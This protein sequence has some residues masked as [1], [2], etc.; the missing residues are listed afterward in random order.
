MA[1]TLLATT[2][3]Q[4]IRVV[5]AL[6]NQTPGYTF[7]SNFRTFTTENGISGF[8][9]AMAANFASSTDAELAAIVTG[10]LGLG[11][12][13]AA[14]NAYLEAQF[15]ADASNRGKAVLDAMNALSTLESDATYGSAAAT[16]NADVVASITYS[17]VSTNTGLLAEGAGQSYSLTTGTDSLTGTSGDDTFTAGLSNT[18]MSLSASDSVNGGAGADALNA[19]INAAGTY[20]L[21]SLSGVETITTAFITTAGTMGLAG[22]TD[23]TKVGV[24]AS[25]VNATYT[26]IA[27]GVSEFVIGSSGAINV[28]FGMA[29]G[30]NAGAED[31][32]TLTLNGV[33]HTTTNGTNTIT[34]ADGFETVNVASSSAN[35]IDTFNTG[36]AAT[37]NVSG[38]GNLTIGAA[39]DAQVTTLDGSAATGVLSIAATGTS[40]SITGGSGNDIIDATAAAGTHTLVGGAGDDAFV[41]NATG[42]LTAADTV[43]GGEGTDTI[44]NVSAQ[45]SGITTALTKVTGVEDI[46]VT[47][48]HGNAINLTRFGSDVNKLILAEDADNSAIT[49]NAGSSTIVLGN[50]AA[51]DGGT[52]A[53]SAALTF[54]A[55][56]AGT[57]DAVT[58]QLGTALADAATN[59]IAATGVETLTINNTKVAQTSTT[60]FGA[61]TV[62]S[63]SG[64]TTTVN[65]TGDKAV[66]TGAITAQTIDASGM[67]GTGSLF[68]DVAAVG[69]TSITGS[70]GDDTLV[71]DASSTINGGAGND[72]ITG[73]AN[74]DTLNGG[75]GNDAI[76]T[77][78]GVDTVDGGAGNDT[79][80]FSNGSIAQTDT[81]DG[82]EGTDTLSITSADAL[83]VSSL[84]TANKATMDANLSNLEVLQ[85]S[86]IWDDNFD[87]SDL[88]N[89]S[90]IK[91]GTAAVGSIENDQ[92]ITK[93][94]DGTTVEYSNEASAAAD[95]ATLTMASATGS[96]DSLTIKLNDQTA[97]GGAAASEFGEIAAAGVETI[98]INSTKLSTG[99]GT[100]NT[101]DLTNAAAAGLKTLNI[102]G[103]LAL[104]S[105]ISSTTLTAV[106][107]SSST[108]TGTTGMDL[109]ATATTVATTFTGT[110]ADDTFHAGSAADTLNGG[111]G[112][113]ILNGNSGNDTLN[114][115]V[116]ADTLDGG[117]GNDT[118]NGGDG[119][120]TINTSGGTDTVDGGAGTDTLVINNSA[121]ANIS[122][123]TISNVETLNMAGRATTMT[124]AQYNLFTTVSNAGTAT[125]T[126]AGTVALNASIVGVTLANGTNNVTT[127][128][129]AA[130]Y[131]ITGGTGADTFN[132]GSAAL[133]ASDSF[134]GG[135]G[136]DTVNVT[137]NTAVVN[138]DI[139][140]ASFNNVE[141]INFA[142]TSTNITWTVAG[143]DDEIDNAITIDASSL[144]TGILTLNAALETTGANAITAIGGAADDVI[145]GGSGADVLIGN[146]GD[147][148][149]VGGPGADSF[150]GGAGADTFR[151]V[152]SASST[153]TT[154]ITN[155]ITDFSVAQVDIFDL[156][157]NTAHNAT[158]AR[159][160]Y[161]EGALDNIATTIGMQTFTTNIT[162]V[163]ASTGPT[164]AEM[165]TYF[166]ANDVF[167][168]AHA[169]S[170]VY[171]AAD[172]GVNT[173]IM[174]LQS[175]GNDK[176]FTALQ[177]AG[178]VVAI[179][180]G[181]T[182]ASVLSNANFADFS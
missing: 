182:D 169:D 55:S 178:V 124:A 129:T 96:T 43:T 138:A 104:T 34:L 1:L 174:E 164:E 21:G 148:T 36:T 128:A 2:D 168:V 165:E 85:V 143:A 54:S 45:L 67:T 63:S 179:L 3:T 90:T 110:A 58:V 157:T 136:T 87:M 97:A 12:A 37:I 180:S 53:L 89:I 64:G 134:D 121:Y 133:A 92:T 167:F 161:G 20:Q 75:E 126:D 72:T 118:L 146:A 61:V 119:A 113:D 141:V 14:G 11:D 88:E 9:N 70:L 38:A 176:I 109:T 101:V 94:V 29:A 60:D 131:A 150:T 145:T 17:T 99:T 48:D 62:T 78:A 163:A 71:G 120:D 137:G 149:L 86:T 22:A 24:N 112:D 100:S 6:Y 56:G 173:Y 154:D 160:V 42:T 66:R 166:A 147:D 142:N 33:T 41:F 155:T 39:L 152:G 105:I 181:V 15:A 117:A 81:V 59:G 151:M 65:V 28:N 140:A 74:N 23:V 95:T 30:A 116:G 132:I 35:T 122:G 25:T 44:Q 93:V 162:V 76:T 40:T 68:Q 111:A 49:L 91:L 114:G 8:A 19:T 139:D 4:I 26:G 108:I 7:L 82:G 156:V 103:D 123:W 84:S 144:T 177:D 153:A 130:N 158:T 80:T 171:V 51:G 77:N 18:A 102:S 135:A 5:E 106:D 16:F 115:D 69:V 32:A 125:L 159:T 107:A 127:S 98:N 73:G 47:N 170:A 172:D 46:M 83:V 50:G 57:D 10:N 79:I 52:D 31:S 13:T 175:G 27:D